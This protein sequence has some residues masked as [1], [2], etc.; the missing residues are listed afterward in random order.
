MSG[1]FIEDLTL[2]FLFMRP[3]AE[4]LIFREAAS[5]ELRVFDGAGDIAISI[6]EVHCSRDADRSALRINEYLDVFGHSFTVGFSRGSREA[7]VN[8]MGD[9]AS[10]LSLTQ[11]DEY[12]HV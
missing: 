2:S 5:T 11:S 8:E 3:I 9:V 10:T 12:V 6:D 1:F 7:L 4:R